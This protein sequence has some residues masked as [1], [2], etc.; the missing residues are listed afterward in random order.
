V[1]GRITVELQPAPPGSIYE[2]FIR[3]G[4][5]NF[6]DRR[7]F[8]IDGVESGYYDVA[9]LFGGASLYSADLTVSGRHHGY[10]RAGNVAIKAGSIEGTIESRLD[11]HRLTLGPLPSRPAALRP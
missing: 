7:G 6:A 2:R 4:Y 10:L 5:R 9:G 1:T 3:V 11:G 8:V